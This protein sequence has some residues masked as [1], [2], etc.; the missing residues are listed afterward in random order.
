MESFENHMSLVFDIMVDVKNL[1]WSQQYET[2]TVNLI[3]N[4]KFR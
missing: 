1:K 2:I 4:V 3:L